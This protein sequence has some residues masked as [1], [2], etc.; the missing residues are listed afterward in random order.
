MPILMS[1]KPVRAKLKDGD[2]V[3]LDGKE[4]KDAYKGNDLSLIYRVATAAKPKDSDSRTGEA[5][6]TSLAVDRIGDIIDPSGVDLSN[7]LQNPVVLMNHDRDRIVGRATSVKLNKG[8]TEMRALWEF[9]GEDIS[10]DA[11]VVW[12]LWRGGFLNAT[13][14]G[15][16]PKE[17]VFADEVDGKYKDIE[18]D[19]FAIS[20][21]E[22]VE[23]SVVTLPMNQEALRVDGAKG[24]WISVAKSLKDGNV[25]EELIEDALGEALEDKPLEQ[26]LPGEEHDEEEPEDSVA[27]D[28]YEDAMADD[29]GGDLPRDIP[30]KFADL[31]EARLA[32]V[33]GAIDGDSFVKF[34]ED[35]VGKLTDEIR[36]W[37]EKCAE[38]SARVIIREV[39][40]GS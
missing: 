8:R 9:V 2:L 11:E 14:V 37:R 38:L 21:S 27:Y 25:W 13:S 1:E 3:W 39:K 18:F 6:I 30:D 5:I 36:A 23:F 17:L 32:F 31:A 26:S 22:L 16:I 4:L 29:E 33:S 24:F 12:K 28:G 10:E 15:I 7:Y 19:G 20:K 40:H 35:H 34:V